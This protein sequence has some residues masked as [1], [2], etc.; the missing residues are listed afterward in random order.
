MQNEQR[1][2]ED[3][4]EKNTISGREKENG[5]NKQEPCL[6]KIRESVRVQSKIGIRCVGFSFQRK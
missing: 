1:E 2:E 3:V 6:N 5:T 4:E